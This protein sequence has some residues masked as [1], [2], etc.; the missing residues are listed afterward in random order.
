MIKWQ[1]QNIMFLYEK[2]FKKSQNYRVS[3]QVDFSWLGP[4]LLG[5]LFVMVFS[6]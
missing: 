1:K 2:H 5:T 4:I 6:F 3:G